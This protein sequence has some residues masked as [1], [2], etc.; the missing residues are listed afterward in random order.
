MKRRKFAA[1]SPEMKQS[2]IWRDKGAWEEMKTDVRTGAWESVAAHAGYPATSKNFGT[3]SES[4]W[5]VLHSTA[6]KS[7]LVFKECP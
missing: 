3:S 1:G 4:H 7:D 2:G 5:S 6:T